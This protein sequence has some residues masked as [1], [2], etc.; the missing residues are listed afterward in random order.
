MNDLP[1]I[2]DEFSDARRN[3]F[4]KVK[5]YKDSGK[6]IVGTFCT[7]TPM[8]VIYA[9]GAYPISLCGMS[10]ET[11][12]DAEKDLP[13]NL[14]PL[15]KS[16]YGFALTEK[17]PF[18]YF[19]DIIVGETT[20]DGKKKMY[21]YLGKLKS[22]HVMQLPQAIDREYALS[23]WKREIVLLKERLE[24]EFNVE[25]TE[26]DLREAIKKC[27]EER[28]VLK[29]LYSLCKMNPS[30]ITGM[31]VHTVLH[32]ASFTFDKDEVMADTNFTDREKIVVK[33]M[34]HTTGDFDYRNIITFNH[35]FM[36]KAIEGIKA[37]GTIFTDTK[38]AYMGINKKALSKSKCDLK[39]FID[40]ERAFKLSQ[41]LE[42][43][44]SACT[45]ELAVEEGIDMFVIGN[46]PTALFRLLELVEKGKVKP[47][48]IIGVPV[49]F[50]GAGESKEHL[51]GFNIPSISTVGTKGGSNVAA[52]I[53]NALLYMVVG[54]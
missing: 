42:T 54:R 20:C 2:F 30:P 28:R 5:E 52:S 7:F 45:V 29:D 41:E 50:V 3:S 22:M 33:R 16:S 51:R 48:F 46:A 19:S 39:C 10:D 37:G 35:D 26:D 18:T 17:C 43:T 23:I 1:K 44:R 53:I 11:I 14:C 47:K 38:M 32:G 4:L 34:I 24:K 49:G 21:E 6:H 25:I 27:N 8:E 12:P 13:K 40:D 15:I 9:A 31:E 36:D